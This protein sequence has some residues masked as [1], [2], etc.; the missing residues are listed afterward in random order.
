MKRFKIRLI[1]DDEI[2]ELVAVANSFAEIQ[3]LLKT[4]YQ[5]ERYRAIS[6][7]TE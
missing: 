4:R 1:T 3:K 7:K 5:L 6:I 2:K